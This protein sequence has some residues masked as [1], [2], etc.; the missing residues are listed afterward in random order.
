MR[1]NGDILKL[2]HVRNIVEIKNAT[3]YRGET[4]V[5]ERLS[6][7]IT[8]GQNTAILGPNGAGKSTLLKLLTR[9]IYPL[10]EG[11]GYVRVFGH[12][13][14]NVWDIRNHLGVVSQDLQAEYLGDVRGIDVLLSG[15]YSSIGIWTH[16]KFT[17]RDLE[18]AGRMLEILG[19]SNCEKKQFRE[20]ST[21]EQRRLLLGRALINGPEALVLDEPTSGLDIRACFQY[22]T[23]IGDLIASGKTVVLVTHHVHEIPPGIERVVLLKDGKVAAD[24]GKAHVMTSENLTDLFDIP[25]EVVHINGFYQAMPGLR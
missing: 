1:V 24:G 4:M 21:G 6:L 23:I 17:V 16:Q 18:R 15:L 3:V 7:K 5:F 20:M 14:W 9:E 11:E 25:V 12:G 8:A 13:L 10:Q 2:S 19:V 22:L